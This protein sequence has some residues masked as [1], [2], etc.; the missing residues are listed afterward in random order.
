[1][2]TNKKVHLIIIAGIL[3][4]AIIAILLTIIISFSRPAYTFYYPDKDLKSLK[5]E[6]RN[7]EHSDKKNI[8]DEERIV[9][10]YLL[11][12]IQY[13]LKLP[14]DDKVLLKDF[15]FIDN[16]KKVAV[17]LS[18][19]NVFEQFVMTKNDSAWW[20]I[21]G[22][23]ETIKANTKIEKLYILVDGKPFRKKVGSWN[24]GYAVLIRTKK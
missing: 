10:E 16:P 17:I 1:M 9:R 24:L 7:I 22:L 11:G 19:N 13:D 2:S 15:W 20:L 12:P 8:T 23:V 21:N 3:I 14:L 4:F 5:S 6:K 18:F